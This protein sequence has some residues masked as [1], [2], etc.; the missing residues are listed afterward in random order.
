MKPQRMPTIDHEDLRMF[1]ACI[2][3]TIAVKSKLNPNAKPFV[4]NPKAKEFQPSAARP[5]FVQTPP[6][7]GIGDLP[8]EVLI[9]VLS[10]LEL[11]DLNRCGQV[12]KRLRSISLVQ[13]LWQTVILLNDTWNSDCPE[14]TT[15]SINIVERILDRGCTTL[16]LQRCRLRGTYPRYF[17]DRGLSKILFKKLSPSPSSSQLINLDLYQC[18]FTNGSLET[19]MLSCHSLKKF[20]LTEYNINTFS[21]SILR[22]FY[23][24]NGQSLQILNLA[25]THVLD[26]EHIKLIVKNCVQLKEV[27]FSD[28][29]L[30]DHCM[31]LLVNGITKN[32]ERIGL[33][34]SS[35]VSDHSI[36][37]LAS[38]CNKIKSLNLA[39]NYISDN[40]LISIKQHLKDTLEE[41]DVTGCWKITDTILI[42]MRSMPK[43]KV[44]NYFK[45]RVRDR[46][47]NYDV[48]KKYLP[49]LTNINPLEKWKTWHI[50]TSDSFFERRK[51]L[52]HE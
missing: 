4:L 32:V 22:T 7:I 16:S 35:S 36:A 8:V 3:P 42:K 31:R 1:P 12:S 34:L 46:N 45:K 49:Q 43:L 27:D 15:M 47:C 13:S 41:L 33:A 25:F 29:C 40:S 44:L 37:I 6:P 14:K 24:Q 5:P 38:R 2:H 21:L 20:S 19:L 18:D 9:N 39:F 11:P 17:F 52:F 51:W 50:S 48:L 28:C 23:S 10:F 30:S 26:G